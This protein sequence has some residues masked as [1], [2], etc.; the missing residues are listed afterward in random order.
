VSAVAEEPQRLPH[1]TLVETRPPEFSDEALAFVEP[2]NPSDL[3]RQMIRLFGRP[4]L[5]ARLAERAKQ[6]YAPIN[7]D[8]VVDEDDFT[9]D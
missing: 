3:A 4:D 2:N 1:L 5:R 9:D 7:W 6:E 8:V